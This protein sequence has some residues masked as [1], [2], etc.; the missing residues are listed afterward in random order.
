VYDFV[1]YHYTSFLLP[2]RSWSGEG[3][4]VGRGGRLLKDVNAVCR[5]HDLVRESFWVIVDL[6]E[7][8]SSSISFVKVR[9]GCGSCISLSSYEVGI[10]WWSGTATVESSYFKDYCVRCN[11]R[12]LKICF[13]ML[14]HR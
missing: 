14:S 6:F 7:I 8:Q 3:I 12:V 4:K 13:V 5:I 10:L 1:C 2:D 11:T 9:G